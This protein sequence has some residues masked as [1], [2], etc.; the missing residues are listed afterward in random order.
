MDT[1]R[2]AS[3]T[4]LCCGGPREGHG[5]G[6]GRGGITQGEMPDVGDGGWRQQTTLPYVYLCNIPA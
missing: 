1:G 6:G 3:H 4:G 5:V 2:E